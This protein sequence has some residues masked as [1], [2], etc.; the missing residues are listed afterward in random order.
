MYPCSS[1]GTLTFESTTLKWAGTQPDLS[2]S[3]Y[4]KNMLKSL[5]SKMRVR[6]AL[7]GHIECGLIQFLLFPQK[8]ARGVISSMPETVL[9]LL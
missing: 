1:A 5:D 7:H 9:C 3:I 4:E 6:D 2:W 8:H